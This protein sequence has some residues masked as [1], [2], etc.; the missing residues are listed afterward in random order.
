VIFFSDKPD[1]NGPRVAARL[2]KEL[3]LA[4][5]PAFQTRTDGDGPVRPAGLG[6]A[7]REAV[8]ELGRG[9][10]VKPMYTFL[11]TLD[12]PRPVQVAAKVVNVGGAT[13]VGELRYET[14]LAGR[15]AGPV[16]LEEAK[17]LRRSRFQGDAGAAERLNA[18]PELVKRANRLARDELELRAGDKV[19]IRREL[20]LAPDGDGVRLVAVTLPR[21]AWFGLSA[22]FDVADFVAVADLAERAL[23]AR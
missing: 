21:K 1:K 2:G 15:L 22:R 18:V 13:V 19:E 8:S 23:G 12:A 5:A 16:A 3:G 4:A 20:A 9:P 14:R 6:A 7:V 10:A 11:F 17:A